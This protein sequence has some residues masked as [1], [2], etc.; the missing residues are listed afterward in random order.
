MMNNNS[1]SCRLSAAMFAMWE[2][3]LY[4]DTHPNDCD[5][6]ELWKEYADKVNRLRIEYER[7]YGPLT[8][9]SGFGES[10]TKAPWPWQNC[11]GDR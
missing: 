9:E 7:T 5:M 8:P 2:L 3:H 6:S 1:L 10:W 11:V 4:L